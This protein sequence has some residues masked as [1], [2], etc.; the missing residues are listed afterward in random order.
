MPLKIGSFVTY[1]DTVGYLIDCRIT[2]IYDNI[3]GLAYSVIH[4]N[5][6]AHTKVGATISE[7]AIVIY[8]GKLSKVI[9][10]MVMI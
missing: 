5:P 10:E 4:M 2:A 8:Y 7:S 3:D 1:I 6:V 9:D